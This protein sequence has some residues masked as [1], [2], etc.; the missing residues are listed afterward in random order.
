MSL[1][2]CNH[3]KKEHNYV[4]ATLTRIFGKAEICFWQTMQKQIIR[5]QSGLKQNVPTMLHK[6]MQYKEDVLLALD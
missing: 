4:M 5:T 1:R 3:Q 2:E 6:F